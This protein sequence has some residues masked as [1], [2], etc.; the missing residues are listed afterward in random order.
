M[1]NTAKTLLALAP[2]FTGLTEVQDQS[3]LSPVGWALARAERAMDSGDLESAELLIRDA[4]ERDRKSIASWELR[5]RLA[6]VR[7]DRDEEVYCRH[8]EYRHAAAQGSSKALLREMMNSLV[9]MDPLARDLYGMKDRFL[10]KLFPIAATYEKA[11]RPHSAIAV[12]KQILAMDPL[13][14]EAQ[15]SIERIAAAPDPSLAEDAKPKDLFANVSDEWIEEFDAAHSEWA[16]GAEEE[17]TNYTTKTDAGYQVLIQTAESMEQMNGFYREFFNYGTEEGGEHVPHIRVHVFKNRMEYLD[18]GIGPPVEWSGGHFT[19]NAVE[20]Y[21][22]GGFVNMVGTLFHEAAHQFVSLGTRAVGWL[23]E[24][25]ASFFEGTRILP[26]GTVIMNMPANHR[27]FPLADRMEKGWMRSATDGYDPSDSNSTPS[28]APTFRIVIENKYSWGP[29]WYSPTW[30]LVFFLYNYQDPIDGR[31][32]YR[33]SFMEFVDASGG[34]G[35][36]TAI[37]TFEEV[38]L[39]NPKPEMSFVERP[40]GADAVSLPRT[41]DEVDAVWKAWILQLRDEQSGRSEVSRPYTQWGRYAVENK[42]YLVAKEHFEKGLVASP[43]DVDLLLEFADL[44]SDHFKNQ[45]RAVKLGVEAL[46]HLEQE[47]EPDQE[48]IR[49]VERLLSKLDPKRK[50]LARI[51]DELVISLRGIVERYAASGL[52]MMVM[53]VAWRG[54][55][56]LK[57]EDMLAP[58]ERAVRRSGRSL[59]IWEKAYNEENLDGWTIASPSFSA[60]GRSIDASFGDFDAEQFDFQFLCMDRVTAGDFSM[61]ARVLAPKAEVNFCGFVFGQKGP[62]T[63]HGMFHFPGKEVA[64]GGAESGWVDL[65][66][67]YGNEVKTWLHVPV[68]TSTGDDR[69][70]AGVWRTLRLDVVG[71][72]V[73]MWYEGELIGTREYP[74]REVLQGSF[75]LIVGSGKTEFSDIR[76]L[77]RDPLDP[78]SKIERAIRM[79]ALLADGGAVGG[80]FLGRK[81]PFPKV[82][83]W[84]QGERVS[85]EEAGL[86]PQLCVIWSTEQND[87]VR[88]NDWL[89]Y[90]ADRYADVGLKVLSI[91]SPNDD[92]TIE[93]YL[94]RYPF[95]GAVAV[96]Y[97]EKDDRGFGESFELY[98]VERFNLPRVLLLDIDGTVAWEGDPGFSINT[99]PVEPYDSFVDDPLEELVANYKLRELVAWRKAWAEEVAPA[100]HEGELEG[101]LERLREAALFSP[102]IAPDAFAAASRLAGLEAAIAD[103]EGTGE[104]LARDGAEPAVEA[105]FAWAE[106]VAGAELDKDA[107]RPARKLLSSANTKAWEKVIKS[108]ESYEG[109]RGEAHEKGPSLIEQLR[110]RPGRLVQ[111]LVSELEAAAGD[112]DWEAFAEI[113]RTVHDRP[114][115]Y[116]ARE[117]FRW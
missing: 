114:A 54:A 30:G 91:C 62:S 103:L 26:N 32:V 81:L 56:E 90:V 69:T 63:F 17:R 24:G 78:A 55:S 40:E 97:R 74:S 23:N 29:P 100:M 20:T 48:L 10:K 49:K 2:L 6:G 117:F 84:A 25:L 37:Q 8:M 50:T 43:G 88:I 105:L 35:G 27:L 28:K 66:S 18:L 7:G 102:E 15:A 22:D 16:T 75:G 34:K 115:C 46:Y 95:P 58:Y 3:E 106:L 19:G 111:E 93:S 14:V 61:E 1:F 99:L 79:Q 60:A 82:G 101:A 4:Q 98:E 85:W 109:R 59:A 87:L 53:D 31:Y 21:I 107:R 80:S 108:C 44:L 94:G 57:L 110:G 89:S 51:Q 41:V 92:Q 113:A 38:V 116:L 73:D 47:A 112:D 45:D 12:L 83:R 13:N 65:M 33:S 9:D 77:A 52:E 42:D 76:F 72:E 70:S 68:D 71:R 36:E 86:A 39:A 67:S 104:A 96:D 5:A 64:E 11:K